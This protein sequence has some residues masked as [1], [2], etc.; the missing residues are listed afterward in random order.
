MSLRTAVEH[1]STFLSGTNCFG[2]TP[3]RIFAVAHSQPRLYSNSPSPRT[4]DAMREGII[5]AMI[6]RRVK[7]S[8]GSNLVL[9]FGDAVCAVPEFVDVVA[10]SGR[11][12]DGVGTTP[13]VRGAGQ[14][15]NTE[16]GRQRKFH[17]TT[18]TQP[19]ER[20][21]RPTHCHYQ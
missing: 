4:T 1:K 15:L 13:V 8:A 6:Q 11:R 10:G 5:P 9:T 17:E 2:A 7:R 12:W 16:K 19:R 20:R 21:P 18:R 14:A 3:A